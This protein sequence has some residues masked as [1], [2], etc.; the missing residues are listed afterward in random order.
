MAY[1]R[2][3]LKDVVVGDQITFEHFYALDGIAKGVCLSNDSWN[4]TIAVKVSWKKPDGKQRFETMILKYNDKAFKNF[5]LLNSIKIALSTEFSEKKN[6]SPYDISDMQQE[7]NKLLDEGGTN[8]TRI[9]VL[10]DRI[11]S[12]TNNK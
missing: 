11:D 9:K 12:L 1:N 3:R 4:K 2:R 8:H 6:D 7:I 10:Q 5:N